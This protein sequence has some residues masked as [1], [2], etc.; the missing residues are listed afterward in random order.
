M[1]WIPKEGRFIVG[2]SF[3]FWRNVSSFAASHHRL[4]IE[5]SLIGS[6]APIL[7]PVGRQD[8]L[9]L[10]LYLLLLLK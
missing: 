10:S 7:G 6:I 4:R 1:K 3:F 2:L 5:I 8:E 9:M